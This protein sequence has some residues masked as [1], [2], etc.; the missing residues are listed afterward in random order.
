[1]QRRSED[2]GK[3]SLGINCFGGRSYFY[4]KN[5]HSTFLL[6][7]WWLRAFFVGKCWWFVGMVLVVLWGG[8]DGFVG[9]FVASH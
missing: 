8:G 4:W 3:R 6:I 9:G 2:D 1:M 5:I 7:M